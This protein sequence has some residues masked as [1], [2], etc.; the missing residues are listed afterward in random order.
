M[1][2]KAALFTWCYFGR[3]NYGQILQC[4]ATQQLCEEYGLDVTVIKYRP[5][6]EFETNI[7]IPQKGIEREHYERHYKEQYIERQDVKQVQRFRNFISENICMSPQC[8]SIKDIEEEI[9]DKE[10][11]I[12]GSDQLWNPSW[13]DPV[14]LLE[15]ARKEHRVISIATGGVSI[16]RKVYRPV[17]KRIAKGLERFDFVSVREAVSRKILS[18]YTDKKIT[19]VLD[20]TLLI[21]ERKWKKLCACRAVEEKYIF[22]YFLGKL[23]PHKHILKEI[24]G[25]RKIGKIIYI[26]MHDSDEDINT[27]GILEPIV[28]AGPREFLSL[29]RYADIVCTD[30]FHGFVFSL[31]FEKEIFLMDRAYTNTDEISSARETNIMDK[32]EIKNRYANSKKDLLN[33]EAI[34]YVSVKKALEERKKYCR[35]KI[36]Q[37][38]AL[39]PGDRK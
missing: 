20:P 13:F 21:D 26:R 35:K 7:N 37:G 32:L 1:G 18:T 9:E 22:V 3:V 39:K 38:I 33:S 10:L 25:K 29:I 30:S 34:D 4:Y 14:F 36:E 17:L 23:S 16:D 2:K 27:E 31:I 12:V 5:M 15:F 6:K 19:D 8:Y 11:L 28:D 24:A